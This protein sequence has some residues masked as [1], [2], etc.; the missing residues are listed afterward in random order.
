[1]DRESYQITEELNALGAASRR[2]VLF[3]VKQYTHQ[4]RLQEL[5]NRVAD[6]ERRCQVLHATHY[7]H[8]CV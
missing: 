3:F 7:P 1:M 2:T 8:L 5:R 4:S 6:I